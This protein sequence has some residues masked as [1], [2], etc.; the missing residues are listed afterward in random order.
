METWVDQFQGFVLQYLF[1]LMIG[2]LVLIWVC[3]QTLTMKVQ[4]EVEAAVQIGGRCA[5]GAC[6]IGV[7]LTLQLWVQWTL[8]NS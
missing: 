5:L 7:A 8:E 4:T 6:V 1:T 3:V 2:V